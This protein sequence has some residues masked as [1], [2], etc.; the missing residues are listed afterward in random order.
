MS[1]KPEVIRI[2]S[3]NLTTRETC[4][5]CGNAHKDADVPFWFFVE[6][7]EPRDGGALCGHCA[8]D[9]VGDKVRVVAACGALVWNSDSEAVRAAAVALVEALN[10]DLPTLKKAQ[11]VAEKAR[12]RSGKHV[13][14]VCF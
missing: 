5:V 10:S 3:N 14:Q 12:T 9:L 8:E 1:K 11:R 4:P 2:R 6:E 7:D 13:D